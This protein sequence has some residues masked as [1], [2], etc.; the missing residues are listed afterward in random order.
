MSSSGTGRTIRDD[1][2]AARSISSS[3]RGRRA[4]DFS[5]AS[6]GTAIRPDAWSRVIGI[7]PLPAR[8]D[9][10]KDAELRAAAAAI[11]LATGGS[12]AGFATGGSSAGFATGGSLAGL[13]TPRGP[14]AGF[15][16]SSASAGPADAT[17]A[18]ASRTTLPDSA[19]GWVSTSERRAASRSSGIGIATS[20]SPIARRRSIIRMITS[21][22]SRDTRISSIAMPNAAFGR[23]GS[24]GLTCLTRPSPTSTG[25][26]FASRSS[27]FTS[28][29]TGWIERVG[30]NRPDLPTLGAK[31]RTIASRSS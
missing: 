6:A 27:N 26:S 22:P 19:R 13:A 8:G 17:C 3:T 9:V 10:S 30:K 14:S 25:V 20:A 16:A 29:P 11:G 7:G 31:R 21:R 2:S 18:I 15:A 5:G 4:R 28:V 23:A 24:G 1:S 12:S